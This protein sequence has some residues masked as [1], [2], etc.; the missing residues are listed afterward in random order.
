MYLFLRLLSFTLSAVRNLHEIMKS[1]YGIS[2]FSYLKMKKSNGKFLES[3]CNSGLKFCR[4]PWETYIA[5]NQI[6]LE[7]GQFKHHCFVGPTQRPN[8]VMRYLL[9]FVSTV[10]EWE[11][12]RPHEKS[13]CNT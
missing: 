2:H 4:S 8:F 6:E 13:P 1:N 10:S 12:P 9:T 7:G 3:Y 11:R 5:T